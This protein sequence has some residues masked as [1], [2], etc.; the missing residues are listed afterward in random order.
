MTFVAERMN[1]ICKMFR[2]CWI[3]LLICLSASS[4]LGQYSSPT[5]LATSGGSNTTT[6]YSVA[7]TLGEGVIMTLDS[8]A[9]NLTSGFHQTDQI[10][11]GDLNFDAEINTED[12]L[13]FLQWLSCETACIADFDLDDDVDTADLLIFLSIFGN[14]CY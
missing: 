7:W 13:I 8:P 1:Y 10:C 2:H 6:E 11:N 3:I 4:V 9:S 5:V 14:S 12:L